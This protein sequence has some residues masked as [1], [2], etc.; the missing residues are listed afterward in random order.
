MSQRRSARAVSFRARR[1]IDQARRLRVDSLEDR[2]APATFTGV[3]PN[4]AI[5]LNTANEVATFHTDGTTVFVDL[6]NGTATTTGTSVSGGGTA[7]ASFSS[8]TY[9]GNITITDS[10]AN[11]SVAFANSIGSYP[12][13]FSITLND[14]ASGNV[15]FAGSSTFS[16]SFNASTTAGFFASVAT[17]SLTL[18]GAVNLSLTATGHD[19]LLAGALNIGGTTSLA[20][21]VVQLDN[22]LND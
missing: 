12:Q 15:T 5:D 19:I 11:T 17:S 1:S 8:A 9:N 3:G 6:T 20:A 7:T 22:P 13:L 16:S 2:L 14:A 18:S 21:S 10:A 4:L